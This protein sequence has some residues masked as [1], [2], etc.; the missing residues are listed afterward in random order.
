MYFFFHSFYF[1]LPMPLFVCFGFVLCSLLFYCRIL[2]PNNLSGLLL[3]SVIREASQQERPTV[4]EIRRVQK[5][6]GKK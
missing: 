5:K 3:Y 2:F 6:K 1:W 4:R